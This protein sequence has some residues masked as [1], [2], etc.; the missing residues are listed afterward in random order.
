MGL[1]YKW[2]NQSRER[3]TDLTWSHKADRWW[4]QEEKPGLCSLS[5]LTISSC[6]ILFY[7]LIVHLSHL[8]QFNNKTLLRISFVTSIILGIWSP[9]Q[10]NGIGLVKRSSLFLSVS[11]FLTVDGLLPECR[12]RSERACNMNMS[13]VFCPLFT[14]HMFWGS[15]SH[16]AV[17]TDKE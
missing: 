11:L 5:L 13:F 10:E 8:L 15:V 7:F 12:Q 16:Y 6:F 17:P 2:R 14:V 3:G 9:K 1:F 4:N